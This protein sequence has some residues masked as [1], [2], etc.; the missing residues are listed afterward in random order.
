MHI[1]HWNYDNTAFELHDFKRHLH[2]NLIIWNVVGA[3]NS[4]YSLLTY[5]IS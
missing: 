3:W 2:V 4:G 1:L 5:I